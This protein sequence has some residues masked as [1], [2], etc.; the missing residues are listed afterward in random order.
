[1]ENSLV[2]DKFYIP[3]SLSDNLF[4]K[5]I[6]DKY[7]N[8]NIDTQYLYDW[9]NKYSDRKFLVELYPKLGLHLNNMING[10]I[11]DIG[12]ENF[13]YINKDLINNNEI[14]YVQIEPL[15]EN[16]IYNN[17]YLINGV[18]QESKDKYNKFNNFFNIIID[19][20]VLGAESVTGNY[21]DNELKEYI[22]NIL[23]LLKDHGLYIYHKN[24]NY[25][26]RLD[27]DK[28]I[29]PYFELINFDNY[30]S[31]IHV[32]HKFTG[33]RPNWFNKDQAEF[34]FLKKKI[35]NKLVIVSHPDDESVWCGD[36]LDENTHVI[37]I[38]GQ[39]SK[40]Y[41]YSKI[42]ENELS[43]AMKI[44]NSSWE[45]WNYPD[46]KLRWS[47]ENKQKL[48]NDINNIL[49]QFTNVKEI[50][51]HGEL[52]ETGHMD[53]ILVHKNVIECYKN[54]YNNKNKPKL[55][56]F[57]PKLNYDSDDRFDNIKIKKAS[58][59]R[60]KLLDNYKSQTFDFLRDIELDFTPL[61]I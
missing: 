57:N 1:M 2:H 30:N 41:N 3:K 19:V 60:N 58:S 4:F 31:Y 11:L 43:N 52:G 25:E 28:Y 55:F 53:H 33:H 6:I 20:G 49:K 7:K 51:T 50:Y 59:L 48:K 61:N 40:D 23:F 10:K 26:S 13:N 35:I 17:D 9:W 22:E 34:Y 37:V 29:Y 14:F 21:T 16:K 56:L 44:T 15:I 27:F 54:F 18:I 42:R 47:N 32:G 45:M 12:F 24:R 38:C 5:S 46:K 36:N 39:N 8:S